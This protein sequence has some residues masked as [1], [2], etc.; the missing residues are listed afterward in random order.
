MDRTLCFQFFDSF[1]W[2]PANW[3]SPAS[4]IENI[5]GIGAELKI[6][7]SYGPEPFEERHIVASVS[8]IAFCAVLLGSKLA[9]RR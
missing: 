7:L 9:R 4:Y 8:W 5:E 3:E 1:R 6:L 2:L